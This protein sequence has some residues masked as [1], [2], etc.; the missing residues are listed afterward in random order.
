[1]TDPERLEGQTEPVAMVSAVSGVCSVLFAPCCVLDPR[2]AAAVHVVLALLSITAGLLTYRKVALGRID[3]TNLFQA[4]LGFEEALGVILRI[5]GAVL[6]HMP[7]CTV[8]PPA[9]PPAT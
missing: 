3:P 9:A 1:M 6:T 8:L 2:L 5:Y 4:R 7:D